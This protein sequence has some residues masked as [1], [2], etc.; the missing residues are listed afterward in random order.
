VSRARAAY[1]LHVVPGLEDLALEE[2]REAFESVAT[3]RVLRAFDE[4]TSVL[5]VD[6]NAA[7]AD[8]LDLGLIEDAFASLVEADG[9]PTDRSGLA[10]ARTRVVAADLDRALALHRRVWPHRKRTTTFRVVARK[11]GHHAFRRV[12]LQRAVEAGVAERYPGW[13]LVEDDA[14]LEIWCQLVDSTL[15]VGLRLSDETLRQRD[16]KAASLPASL[17]PTVARAMVRLSRPEPDDVVLDPVCGAGTLLIERALEERYAL[18]LGGDID[19][20]AVGAASANVGRRYQPLLL[21]RWDARR[22]PLPDGS[23]SRVLANL[24]FGRQI[25][26]PEGARAL[27]PALLGEVGRVLKPGGLA[28][29]LT[30]ERRLLERSLGAALVH[31]REVPVVVRGYRA[32]IN[33]LSREARGR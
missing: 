5:A 21:A 29:V 26:T 33:V 4:R 3:R 20:E 11:G 31:R 9:L 10:A 23:V 25:G 17:K 32:A 2:V 18:L 22:L 16:Y 14:D 24:P 30:P 1:L 8:L 7:P 12:D 19:G 27:Y 15:V 28:V 6:A 13:R